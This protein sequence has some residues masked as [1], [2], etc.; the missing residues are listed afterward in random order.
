MSNKMSYIVAAV[1]M[2]VYAAPT[3]AQSPSRTT[4]PS[5]ETLN[6]IQLLT[7]EP[8]SRPRGGAPL[9][10]EFREFRVDPENL[11]PASKERVKVNS[12]GEATVP[13][14]VP[15]TMVIQFQPTAS[16]ESI[17]DLLKNRKLRVI[18]TFPKLG[19]VKLEADLTKY[20]GP[21]LSDMNAN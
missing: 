17:D 5:S 18:E 3:L 12:Q 14:L 6:A 15:N 4:L 19:A 8:R 11:P 10:P 21:A 16:K 7:I 1:I 13:L 9:R 20:F 2:V